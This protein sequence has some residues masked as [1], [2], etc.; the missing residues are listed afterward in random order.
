[1]S[2]GLGPI[3]DVSL[4]DARAK[5]AEARA[6]LH[7]GIDPRIHRNAARD[8]AKAASDR[9]VSFAEVFETYLTAQ[10]A[11]WRSARQAPLWRASMSQ[12][13]LP[14]IG[15]LPVGAINTSLVLKVLEPLWTVIPETASRLRGRI[16]SV[17]SYA[18]A[19]GWREGPNPAVWR[20]HLALMLPKKTKVRSVVHHPALDWR[21]APTLLAEL[22]AAD[23]VASRALQFL[24]LTAARTGEVRGATWAE[25]DMDAAVWTIPAERM[26]AQRAHRVPLA[27]AALDVLRSMELLRTPSGLV[28]PGQ[29][30]SRPIGAMAMLRALHALD[31]ADLTVHGFRSTFRD[32]AA[33]ATHYPNHVVE[34]ALAH[35]VG[36]ADEAA[37]R[38]GDLFAKRVALMDDWAAYL[39]QPAAQVVPLR[40]GRRDTGG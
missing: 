37:Y 25:V 1:M 13:V 26:K 11:G 3:R 4:A 9:A 7:Q 17:L 8:A 39:A 16:E 6:L 19:L 14:T 28:F 36:N 38:R 12:H 34:Q 35:T 31:R 40:A 21:E 32:W 15:H 2:M 33:E 22:Q 10:A 20:S 30:R 18:T 5:A 24:I 27:Q 29:T 23:G